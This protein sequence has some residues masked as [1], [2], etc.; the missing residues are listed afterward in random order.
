MAELTIAEF[1]KA[2]PG[3]YAEY[4]Q[5]KY[6]QTYL[7]LELRLS[8]KAIGLGRLGKADLADIA[9][10]GGNQHGIRQR[11][12]A[13]NTEESVGES[14]SKA[15]SLLSSPADAL[16]AILSIN[17]WG[18]SYG[19]KTLRFVCPRNYAA[20]D[21]KLRGA[22]SKDLLPLIYDGNLASMVRGY[23]TFLNICRKI[24]QQVHPPGPRP[25]GVWFLADIEMALFQFAWD[26]NTLVRG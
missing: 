10:W 3:W 20:L 15:I 13:G 5:S 25:G 21:Q 24:G 14:S 2:V 9:D 18:L 17:Q 1:A 23:L 12:L 19:S 8:Q 26:G 11:L 4:T 16:K 22:I 6:F 7:T